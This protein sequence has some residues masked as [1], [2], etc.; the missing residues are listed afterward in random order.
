MY[1]FHRK[2]GV[3]IPFYTR[4]PCFVEISDC[5]GLRV[6]CPYCHKF[7]ILILLLLN[8]YRAVLLLFFIHLFLY[9]LYLLYYFF[10]V[11]PIVKEQGRITSLPGH[12][13][14]TPV[15]A[16][17]QMGGRHL[18]IYPLMLIIDWDRFITRNNIYLGNIFLKCTDII[19]FFFLFAT[20]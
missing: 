18:L 17:G 4:E 1:R 13:S 20:L 3:E 15:T 2:F 16:A 12:T 10:F 11:D 14:P 9:I 7:T 6:C 8:F 19:I 5:L